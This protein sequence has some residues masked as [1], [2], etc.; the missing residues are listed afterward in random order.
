VLAGQGTGV[1]LGSGQGDGGPVKICAQRGAGDRENGRR[2]VHVGCYELGDLTPRHTR[3]AHYERHVDILL[4]SALLTGRE[5]V[6]RDV[7]AIVGGVK[8]VGIIQNARLL[9]LLD[10]AVDKLIDSLQGAEAAA[11]VLVVVSNL[12]VCEAGL[13][14][15]PVGT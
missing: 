4:V 1:Q 5:A 7:I 3:A 10:D 14:A 8:D 11:V 9:K 12:L 15:D 2:E 13:A 6:V